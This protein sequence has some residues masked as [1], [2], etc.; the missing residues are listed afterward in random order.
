VGKTTAKLVLLAGLL[1]PSLA[2]AAG[3]GKLTVLSALG[4]PLRAEI[5]IVSLQS[6]EGE[7][8][9]ARLASPEAFRQ[10]NVERPGVLM[11][12][13]FSVEPR[14]NGRYVLVLSSVEPI[15]EPFLDMLVELGWA[16]GRLVR[17]YTFLLD[18]PEYK[19]PPVA[20]PSVPAPAPQVV[21]PT[22]VPAPQV[23]A[24]RVPPP[25]E[26]KP[27]APAQ[28]QEKTVAPAPAPAA[29]KPRP[30]APVQE[31]ARAPAPAPKPPAP[32]AAPK[33]PATYEVKRGDTLAKIANENKSAG[34][35]LQQMLA[36][37]YRRNESEFDGNMNRMRAGKILTIPEPAEAL[38][39]P[40]EEAREMVVAQGV[41]YT[42]YR[43]Q[44]A[45]AVA[46]AQ[47]RAEGGRQ[48]SG[49]IGAPREE[50][51]A[52]PREPAKDQLRLSKPDDVKGSSA[53]RAAALADELSSREK[54]LK[55]ANERIAQLEKNVQDLQKL[56]ALKSEAG[57][58]MQKAA[59]QP[60]AAKPAAETPTA[61]PAP[62][63]PEPAK[64]E[65]PPPAP[66]PAAPAP[67]APAP[68]AAKAPAKAVTP[69][70]APAEPS[71][72]DE[73]LEDPIALGG[74]GAVVILLAGYGA[75]ALRQKRKAQAESSPF[76]SLPGEAPFGV[77][78][79]QQVDTGSVSLQSD[80][81]QGGVAKIDTEEID[82]IAEA[83]V[84]MAY[85]RDVQAEEILKEALAKDSSR[86][87]IRAKLLEIYA[88]RKDQ[89]AFEATARELYAA[90]GGQGAEWERAMSLG[91]TVDPQ[92]PLYGGIAAAAAAGALQAAGRA[93]E[94]APSG[95][96]GGAPAPEID[97]DLDLSTAPAPSAPAPDIKL[98]DTVTAPEATPASLD[99]DFDLGVGTKAA[100]EAEPAAAEVLAVPLPKVKA[101]EEATAM[102]DFDLGLGGGEEPAAVE[103]AESAGDRT[104]VF[105]VL[106]VQE[107]KLP[108]EL[109]A[110]LDMDLMVGSAGKP[111]EPGKAESAT[112]GGTLSIDAAPQE[113]RVP[114]A[115][116]TAVGSGHSI[117]FD[118][119]PA[120]PAILR[121]T[122]VAD[123]VVAVPTIDFNLPGESAPPA[124]KAADEK[125]ADFDLSAFSLDLGAA[126]AAEPGPGAGEPDSH[127]QEVATKLDLAKAY[128]EMG[129]KEGARELLNEVIKEGDAA[130]QQQATT[131]LQALG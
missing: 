4:Q 60:E 112:D 16:N 128:E 30:P 91:P 79:G 25:V 101:P 1:L 85:G 28:I 11:A 118:V 90:T 18:P 110:S 2:W 88:S 22:P 120:E 76:A 3:L 105:D 10:A 125:P 97:F 52:P 130:Q 19:G 84:Y 13:R 129:D 107:A 9:S 82:P 47:P 24:A 74:A 51:P 121:P 111:V 119:S 35:T 71:F 23:P 62:A 44:L 34:V 72:V 66:E 67:K 92:N 126:P 117:D 73:M 37:L 54:A 48:V 75:Y 89:K 27:L 38:S 26:E 5:E 15:N 21:E 102:V 114:E 33:K 78:G 63:A 95:A 64:A 31:R 53:A 77:S 55:E 94:P 56:L 17:E 123:S 58:Q 69:P 103:K 93:A 49:K 99:F 109:P 80:F 113:A 36:A 81:S 104:L 131:M 124:Q 39:V 127:W 65:T 8:L 115:A 106:P 59:K 87:A 46:G 29:E 100:Q 6:N 43:R 12:V 70:P 98:D 122:T 83:D 96:P 50:K 32:A 57:A 45:A 116:A 68:A 14:P 40:Q 86:Q 42:E 61:K 41:E 7:S 20:T 108:E